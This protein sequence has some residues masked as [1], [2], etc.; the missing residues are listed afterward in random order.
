MGFIK[1][2]KEFSTRGNVMQLAVGII[3]GSAFGKIVSSLVADIIM[4]PIGYLVGGIKFTDLKLW[5]KDAVVDGA[6][7]VTK[8]AIT[9]NVGN[10][11][12]AVF[13]FVLITIAI[14]LLMKVVNK[15]NRKESEE[16]SAAKKPSV[17][18]LLLTEIRDLL[19][20]K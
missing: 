14:F 1:E 2:F 3:I 12:Q 8:E 9:L 20:E 11:I 17:E 19:K 7:K 16:P 13:N 5:L 18:V 4:P 6:G 15:L 10:F